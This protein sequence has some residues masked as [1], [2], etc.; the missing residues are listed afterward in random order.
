MTDT[1]RE[2][3]ERSFDFALRI[4]KMVRHLNDQKQE[5]VLAKQILRSGTSIGA[6]LRESVFA[7]SV[8]DFVSKLSIAL[9]E[10]AETQYWLELLRAA[11]YLAKSQFE[12]LK[13][14]SDWLV[15]TLVNVVKSNKRKLNRL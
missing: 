5:Y 3:G 10:A 13:A 2:L 12:S 14:D 7:Q 6:N 15:G 4:V 9:K 1:G 8:A 11:G